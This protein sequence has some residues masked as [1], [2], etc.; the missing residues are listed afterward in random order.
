[1]NRKTL[2][3]NIREL[4]PDADDE[5][6]G[7]LVD[8]VMA[9]NGRDIKSFQETIAA[10]E[11]EL[12]R[13]KGVEEEYEGVKKANMTAEQQ[14]QAAQDEA[15]KKVRDYNILI[16]RLEVERDFVSAGIAEDDYKELLD[17]IV[18]DDKDS[19]KASAAKLLELLTKEK[20]AAVK[21]TKE[22]LIGSTPRPL[23]N[24]GTSS[25]SASFN[26]QYKAAIENGDMALAA[27]LIRKSAQQSQIDTTTT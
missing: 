24:E 14:L 1:M 23:G 11:S 19:S 7:N 25:S 3:G 27:S 22:E 21:A 5:A 16:N 15:E 9:S 18:T 20:E 6:V 17:V 13:L 4:F 10:N 12:E 26:E 8:K 2:E